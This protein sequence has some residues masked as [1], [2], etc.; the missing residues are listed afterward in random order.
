MTHLHDTYAY[1]YYIY[2]IYDIYIYILNKKTVN[3][4]ILQ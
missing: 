4:V 1:I 2:Y 3:I